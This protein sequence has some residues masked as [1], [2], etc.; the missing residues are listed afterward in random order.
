MRTSDALK[1]LLFREWGETS[2]VTKILEIVERH[3][4]EIE[5]AA[6]TEK[7]IESYM[8]SFDAMLKKIL[9]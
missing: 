7:Q 2:E 6:K 8:N 1:E 5:S 9:P 3:E 4:E